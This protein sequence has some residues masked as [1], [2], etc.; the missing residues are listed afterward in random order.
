MYRVQMRL[1]RIK[2]R[3]SRAKDILCDGKHM[4]PTH[5]DKDKS[6]FSNRELTLPKISLL[7]CSVD[8]S[9]DNVNQVGG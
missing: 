8:W 9:T 2:V 6:F 7:V 5:I 3:T 1:E 4:A